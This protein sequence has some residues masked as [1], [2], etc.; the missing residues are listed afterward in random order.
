[1]QA[2]VESPEASSPFSL[3]KRTLTFIRF[4]HTI[5]AM[6]FAL[7]AMFV[8]ANG[9][10]SLLLFFWICLAMVTARTTA[11]AF[12]R[13]ADW[14][15]DKKNPRTANRHR[16]LT[17]PQAIFL[18]AFSALGFIL[19]TACINSLCFALS[20]VAL[21]IICFY[22]LTK[23]FTTWTQF[24]LGLALAVSPVGAWIAVTGQF[25]WPPLILALAV[26]L[27]VAGF[28]LI[29]ATQD[30]E[31]DRNAGLRSMV[32]KLGI[33]R[34]LHLA[35][36]L[37]LSMFV[38]LILFGGVA[39]LSWVYFAFLP[40]IAATLWYEHRILLSEDLDRINKA[41]FNSNAIVGTLFLAATL[42]SSLG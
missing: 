11:M 30:Y 37:H 41:F 35:R 32:V 33:P 1:M 12:N 17:K 40:P 31:F 27:W 28:D 20:P 19:V 13:I 23:R 5:F 7:G 34:S 24:Y 8:A 26:I 14:E 38:L 42:L 6:P 16:L 21:V 3:L 10:P 39:G 22:S 4:S 2:T 29:Y 15:I 36:I 25:A 18:C 9:W